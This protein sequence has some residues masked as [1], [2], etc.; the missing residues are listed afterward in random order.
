MGGCICEVPRPYS[1]KPE[2]CRGCGRFIDASYVSNDK[3]LG[4]FAAY[5]R[6]LPDL[7]PG[8]IGYVEAVERTKRE[9]RGFEYLAGDMQQKG[10]ALAAELAL[11]SHFYLLWCERN[12]QEANLG[13]A[14]EAASFAAKAWEAMKRI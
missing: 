8:F 6:S 13:A 12:N 2:S 3:S 7:D 5:L 14:M 1:H 11:Q 10:L 4:S 9:G